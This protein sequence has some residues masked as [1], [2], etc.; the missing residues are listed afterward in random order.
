MAKEEVEKP[1][2]KIKW[3]GEL[4]ENLPE[5]R[6]ESFRDKVVDIESAK[7]V[8]AAGEV[9]MDAVHG[10]PEKTGVEKGIDGALED[11]GKK[12][13]T[14]K[15]T[16]KDPIRSKL[17]DALGNFLANLLKGSLTKEG[18][19]RLQDLQK[20]VTE[21]TETIQGKKK[22][23]ELQEIL[24]KVT[25]LVKPLQQEIQ[26]LKSARAHKG[27]NLKPNELLEKLNET[28]DKSKN[29]LSK[30]GYNVEMD[31]GLSKEEIEKMVN[32]AK[33]GAIE[34]LPPEELKK[35]LESAGYKIVGGPISYDQFE[36]IM[37]EAR[38]K[39]E[40]ETLD[41][42]RIDVTADIVKTAISQIVSMFQPAVNVWM[43]GS[44]ASRAPE[45]S[46]PPPKKK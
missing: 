4:V 15:L 39:W 31:K 16:S 12:I 17:D 19:S 22:A 38:K 36:K 41:D 42:K 25:G 20:Q 13:I 30:M 23:E 10:K 27:S 46:S 43:E 21:L 26:D 37:K 28:A 6:G 5:S 9:A 32:A 24:D 7:L 11:V 8:R 1:L 35:R 34:G 2:K 44:L 40:E 33:N 45:H 3:F 14:E 29:L 18:D